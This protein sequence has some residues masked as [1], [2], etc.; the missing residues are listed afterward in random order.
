ML[1]IKYNPEGYNHSNNFTILLEDRGLEYPLSTYYFAI[2][3]KDEHPDV[4]HASSKEFAIKSL[5]YQL[6]KWYFLLDMPFGK[7]LELVLN[8]EDQYRDVIQL[9]KLGNSGEFTVKF[10][11]QASKVKYEGEK[12]FI[13]YE[14]IEKIFLRRTTLELLREELDKTIQ[15]LKDQL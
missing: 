15:Y 7:T 3:Y 5:I 9:E 8:Q 13:D 12:P 11:V 4:K 1:K 10:L 14:L 2:D 6:N